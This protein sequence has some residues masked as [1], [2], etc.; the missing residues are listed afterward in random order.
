MFNVNS[1]YDDPTMLLVKN[2]NKRRRALLDSGADTE[3][4]SYRYYKD[5]RK[6]SL[7]DLKDLLEQLRPLSQ[8]ST[9][10]YSWKQHTVGAAP[11]V[12]L[13]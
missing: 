7:E 5:I 3:V 13:R 12:I 10:W 6:I 2:K 9:N 11:I 1:K 4:I 8:G